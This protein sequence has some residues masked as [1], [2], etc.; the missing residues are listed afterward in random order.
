MRLTLIARSALLALLCAPSVASAQLMPPALDIAEGA[1][2]FECCTYGRWEVTRAVR[3]RSAPDSTAAVVGTV[4]GGDV[5]V[6]ETGEVHTPPVPFLVKQPL[7]MDFGA[8]ALQPGDTIWVL[9][10]QGEGFFNTWVDGRRVSESLGFS[11]Y[12]GTY[13]R[14]CESCPHGELLS[15]LASVWWVRVRTGSGVL[16]WTSE[17]D[18]FTGSDACGCG[19]GGLGVP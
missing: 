16:G 12:G 9:D 13:G 7:T 2:P 14:R 10:Y 8:V 15:D 19:G 18:A 17:S 5:V 11:P 1:C 3:L 4:Q 6:A